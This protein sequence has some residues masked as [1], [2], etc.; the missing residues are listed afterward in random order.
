MNYNFR[1]QTYVDFSSFVGLLSCRFSCLLIK[2]LILFLFLLGLLSSICYCYWRRWQALELRIHQNHSFIH[3]F[4]VI[5]QVVEVALEH[6]H[7]FSYSIRSNLNHERLGP[8]AIARRY[9]QI[10]KKL[11]SICKLTYQNRLIFVL[12]TSFQHPDRVLPSTSA[13]SF[14]LKISAHVGVKVMDPRQQ[15]CSF[16]WLIDQ[17]SLLP[18]VKLF[19][20]SGFGNLRGLFLNSIQI[21]HLSFVREVDMGTRKCSRPSFICLNLLFPITLHHNRAF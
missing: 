15:C 8:F 17:W 21:R 4:E 10:T 2:L 6:F 1:K 18:A 11:W 19:G 5:C 13:L 7:Q 9:Y 14:E 16:S 20:T 3:E 12:Q